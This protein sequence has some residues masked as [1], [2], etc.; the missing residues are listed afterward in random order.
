[1]VEFKPIHTYSMNLGKCKGEY[2]LYWNFDPT[3]SG[4][5]LP[6]RV[7]LKW[8]NTVLDTGFRGDASYNSVLSS[9]GYGNVLS[10]S[11][12]GFLTLTKNE[13]DPTTAEV[14]V[15]TPME[16]SLVQT[17]L[18]CPLECS[19]A[20]TVPLFLSTGYL[21][22]SNNGYTTSIVGQP[23]GVNISWNEPD[24]V[25][26][27][28]IQNYIVEYSYDNGNWT[29]LET[30]SSNQRSLNVVGL[31]GVISKY[32][33]R[34]AGVNVSGKG[35]FSVASPISNPGESGCKNTIN[36]YLNDNINSDNDVYTLGEYVAAYNIGGV[37]PTTVNGVVFLPTHTSCP[38]GIIP[39]SDWYCCDQF[40]AAAAE[41]YCGVEGPYYLSYE[42]LNLG[43]SLGI[44]YV[45]SQELKITTLG[46]LKT[47][48]SLITNILPFSGLSSGYRSLLSSSVSSSSRNLLLEINNLEVGAQ[49]LIQLWCNVSKQSEDVL[50]GV[51]QVSGFNV[52]GEN[53]NLDLYN[54]LNYVEGSLGKN[55]V[56]TFISCGTNLK[57]NL[58]GLNGIPPVINALQIRKITTLACC[59]STSEQ[60]VA[61]DGITEGCTL[62]S[63]STAEEE[64]CN[65]DS[66]LGE[67]ECGEN[68]VMPN[69]WMCSPERYYLGDSTI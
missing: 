11:T 23:V 22:A 9:L 29:P 14:T 62:H 8:G 2:K 45:Y 54:N 4:N 43:V 61:S 39:Y 63:P 36:Y 20:P 13:I 65:Y 37:D 68:T 28:Q 48:S 38:N 51:T 30:I 47:G 7:R 34:V 1:M 24:N 31:P 27:S 44:S 18:T 5:K 16:E 3:N 35:E 21:Y 50:F 6:C 59:R 12:N 32:V 58:Q 66:Y 53:I 55:V 57:I 69:C 17:N 67:Y 56:G 19:G 52:Y 60:E 26:E 10:D 40:G 46:S 49:Y 42:Q 25:G 33:F 41:F 15:Y 64:C